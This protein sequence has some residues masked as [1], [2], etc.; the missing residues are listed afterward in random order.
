MWFEVLLEF[1][2][3]FIH[4]MFLFFVISAFAFICT[5]VYVAFNWYIV[6]RSSLPFKIFKFSVLYMVVFLLII[7]L[8]NSYQTV[9]ERHKEEV[10]Y[11]CGH[12]SIFNRNG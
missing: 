3:G 4:L 12:N 5:G 6:D 10:K 11:E 9:V 7:H 1:I 8:R 2:I